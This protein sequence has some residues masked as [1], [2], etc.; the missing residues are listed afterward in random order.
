MNLDELDGRLFADV[1]EVAEITGLDPRT[2]RRA[3][4]AKEIPAHKVGTKWMIPTSWLREQAG[5]P[6]PPVPVM[7]DVDQLA[8]LVADRLFARFVRL[9]GTRREEAI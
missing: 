2:I 6:T 3:A 7:P 1:P 8:D 9:F 4:E 5:T